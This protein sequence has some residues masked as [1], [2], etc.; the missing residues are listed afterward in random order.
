MA[1]LVALCSALILNML[2]TNNYIIRG[3]GRREGGV[4]GVTIPGPGPK[5]GPG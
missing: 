5:G 1:L 2:I 4:P 3:Q